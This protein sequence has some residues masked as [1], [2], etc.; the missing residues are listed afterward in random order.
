MNDWY[1]TSAEKYRDQN[2]WCMGQ[3]YGN[4]APVSKDLFGNDVHE[5]GSRSYRSPMTGSLESEDLW[6]NWS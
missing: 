2:D 4:H 5:D 3:Y 6:G 1:E